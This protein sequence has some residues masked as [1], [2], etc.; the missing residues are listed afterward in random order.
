ML[1]GIL[2]G[3]IGMFVFIFREDLVSEFKS[4][5]EAWNAPDAKLRPWFRCVRNFFKKAV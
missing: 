3:A 2:I 1:L 5:P 4:I